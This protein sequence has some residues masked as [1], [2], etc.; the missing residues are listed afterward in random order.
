MIQE[1]I[2]KLDEI[3]ANPDNEP[4]YTLGGYIIGTTIIRDDIEELQEQYLGLELIGDLG[5]ELETTVD[6]D[7]YAALLFK[8]FQNALAHFKITIQ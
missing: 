4:L 2:K 8:K 6:D 3:S 1:I 7:E 5:D